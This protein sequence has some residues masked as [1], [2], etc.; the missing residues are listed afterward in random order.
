MIRHTNI[1]CHKGLLSARKMWFALLGL[2]A[3]VN[4]QQIIIM[5]QGMRNKPN[6]SKLR[7]LKSN[8]KRYITL[9]RHDYSKGRCHITL[10]TLSYS[11][12]NS[13]CYIKSYTHNY[14]GG[15]AK[16]PSGVN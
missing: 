13:R 1:H 2:H 7:D 11:I 12:V 3:S 9:L 6:L 5:P 10:Y 8:V 15:H 14:V 4:P 16:G